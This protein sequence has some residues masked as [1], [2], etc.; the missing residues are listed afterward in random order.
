MATM[1]LEQRAQLEEFARQGFLSVPN[2]LTP[3]QIWAFNREID[4]YLKQFPQEWIH[5]DASL[6][7]TVNVLPRT[8]AFDATIENRLTLDLLRGLLGDEIS[9]EEFS[10]MIRYP[11]TRAMDIKS[12]H[13]D[14]TRDYERRNEIQ[15][16]SLIY[17]L[18]DVTETDHC[19]S[20]IPETHNRLV[21]YRP[22]DVLP[23]MERDLL[24]PAGTAVLF[25]ARCLHSGKLKPTSRER[26]TLHLYYSRYGQA[27]TSEWSDIPARLFRKND[28]T[29][30]SHLY[31]KWNLTD[32]F[33]GTGKKPKDLDPAMPAAD[34]IREVQRRANQ[35]R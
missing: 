16:I 21:D 9:F 3:A 26:R 15:A 11:T 8:S 2:A 1:P 6:V 28:P 31:S 17:Y 4:E 22:D 14:I 20:I 19:F 33:E 29:L 32:V 18:T 10:I 35:N 30:P 13:R 24:G 7:Q 5:F 23:G 27:R 25:H 12:W 34:M